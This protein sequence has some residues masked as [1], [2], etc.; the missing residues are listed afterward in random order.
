M[1]ETSPLGDRGGAFYTL[2]KTPLMIKPYNRAFGAKG[3]HA[4]R[5]APVGN[6]PLFPYGDF[7]RRGKFIRSLDSGFISITKGSAARISP[8]GGDVTE[9]DRRGVFPR[10]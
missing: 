2:Y 4:D 6:A 3:K 7:P 10:A 5:A 8:S 9:G 1:G